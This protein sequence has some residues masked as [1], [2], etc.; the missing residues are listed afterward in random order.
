MVL[1]KTPGGLGQGLGLGLDLGFGLGLG[2]GLGLS[3]SGSRSWSWFGSG[4]GSGFECGSRPGFWSGCLG[5][6]LRSRK[7][8]DA[9]PLGF[10]VSPG[11]VPRG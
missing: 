6:G 3:G 1:G 5:S 8:A 9:F 4:S 10:G 2:L 7:S 11:T